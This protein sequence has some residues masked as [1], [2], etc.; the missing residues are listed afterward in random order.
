LHDA[1]EHD[2]LASAAF[3]VG[4]E[5]GHG[6]CGIIELRAADDEDGAVLGNLDVRPRRG[7]WP[8]ASGLLAS[9]AGA[10]EVDGS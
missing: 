9:G 3:F 8:T 7:A 4:L 1:I 6:G 10:L 5:G 2:E